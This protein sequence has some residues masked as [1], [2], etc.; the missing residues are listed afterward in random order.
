MA[1]LTAFD[2][3]SR[4]GGA[5]VWC[6]CVGDDRVTIDIALAVVGPFNFQV[7]PSAALFLLLLL[8]CA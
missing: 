3:I 7:V 1:G 2:G 8:H 4:R 6:V 5:E